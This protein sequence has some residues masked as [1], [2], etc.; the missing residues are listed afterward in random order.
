MRTSILLIHFCGVAGV[1]ALAG[2]AASAGGTAA[3]NH[4]P[5]PSGAATVTSAPVASALP[6]RDTHGNLVTLADLTGHSPSIG[7][8]AGLAESSPGEVAFEGGAASEA[9]S[10]FDNLEIVG[11]NLRDKLAVLRVGSDRSESNLLS[12]FA[13]V[14]NK[15]SQRLE[16]EMQTVYRDKEGRPLGDGR[17]SWVPITLKPHEAT[18]YRSVA[19]SEDATDFLVRIRHASPPSATTTTGP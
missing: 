18:Q 13:G 14:K 6:V 7:Q 3:G 5:A 1:L 11:G 10:D 2:C 12:V 8:T 4:A 15:T 9:S 16:L 17:S 19:L